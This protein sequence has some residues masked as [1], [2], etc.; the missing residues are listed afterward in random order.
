MADAWS[1]HIGETE[2]QADVYAASWKS[3]IRCAFVQNEE[4]EEEFDVN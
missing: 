1:L 4:E 2:A 3:K